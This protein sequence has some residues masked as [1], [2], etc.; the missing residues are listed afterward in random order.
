MDELAHTTHAAK[1]P[2]NIKLLAECYSVEENFSCMLLHISHSRHLLLHCLL[3]LVCS[4]Y[5]SFKPMDGH[6]RC[7][8]EAIEGC[9]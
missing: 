7:R 1:F 3:A 9:R 4:L 8:N 5:Q 6:M 2:K